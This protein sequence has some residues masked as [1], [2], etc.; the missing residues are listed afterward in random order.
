MSLRAAMAR[1]C[2]F[3]SDCQLDGTC[4]CSWQVLPG[5]SHCISRPSHRTWQLPPLVLDPQLM[6][7]KQEFLRRGSPQEQSPS[8]ATPH[9]GEQPQRGS[10]LG[11]ISASQ[12]LQGSSKDIN[13]RFATFNSKMYTS[14]AQAELNKAK[15]LFF[16]AVPAVK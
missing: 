3:Q 12:S 2:L 9:R 11:L 14:L 1:N 5:F 13:R 16:F 4:I 15:L 7:A 6:K 8:M 10:K